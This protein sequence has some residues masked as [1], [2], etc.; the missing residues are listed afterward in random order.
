METGSGV[1][2]GWMVGKGSG[3]ATMVGDVVDGRGRRRCGVPAAMA[4]L[5]AERHRLAP[6]TLARDVDRSARVEGEGWK[7]GYT[8]WQAG[9]FLGKIW[10]LSYLVDLI[11]SRSSLSADSPFLRKKGNRSQLI[12]FGS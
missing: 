1:E 9:N 10:K 5:D 7:E 8:Q 6:A 11:L 12:R 4:V 3:T 2:G